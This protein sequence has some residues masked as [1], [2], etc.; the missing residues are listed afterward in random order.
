VKFDLTKPYM[1]A[2][3]RDEFK[4]IQDSGGS[5]FDTRL[6]R[7]CG[8]TEI[9]KIKTFCKREEYETVLAGLQRVIDEVRRIKEERPPRQRKTNVRKKEARSGRMDARAAKGSGRKKGR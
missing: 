9:P 5:F 8:V 3:E 2:L 1:T 7:F 6:C 4:R